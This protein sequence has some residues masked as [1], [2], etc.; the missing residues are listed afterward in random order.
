MARPADLVLTWNRLVDAARIRPVRFCSFMRAA[1]PRRF[2]QEVQLGAAHLRR[3][4]Q[5]DLVD[6]RRVQ[7]EDALDAL[8]ER[9]LAH[10]EGGADAAPVHADH[11]AFEH[12][13]ALLVALAHLHVH[14]DRVARLHRRR[15]T[16][17]AFS[18]TSSMRFMTPASFPAA[19]PA[20]LPL[21]PDLVQRPL[22]VGAAFPGKPGPSS[23]SGRRSSVRSSAVRSRQRA[24]CA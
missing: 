17:C 8:A 6:R 2:A 10:R 12:L 5:L 18:T 1:L 3:A 15:W 14:A 19:R 7:R 21:G 4:D 16:S 23:R 24:T 22:G 13:D 9:H 20:P 11:H